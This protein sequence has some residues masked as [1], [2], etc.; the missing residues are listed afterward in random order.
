LSALSESELRQVFAFKGGTALK[1]SLLQRLSLFETPRFHIAKQLAYEDI[2]AHLERVY[3]IAH[4]N[5]SIAF[6][7]DRQDRQTHVPDPCQQQMP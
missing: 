4:E 2:R 3:A 1:R 7:I 5:S 6:A